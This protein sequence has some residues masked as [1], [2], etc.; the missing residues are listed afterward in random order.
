[1]PHHAPVCL[2]TL[3]MWVGHAE[4][5]SEIVHCRF[6][7]SQKHDHKLTFLSVTTTFIGMYVHTHIPR[8]DPSLRVLHWCTWQ[9]PL[10][11]WWCVYHFAHCWYQE[12]LVTLIWFSPGVWSLCSSLCVC[13][14]V[15]RRR[16]MIEWWR[17]THS[18]SEGSNICLQYAALQG[19][20]TG[21]SYSVA[22]TKYL[23]EW[24]F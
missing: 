10:I 19:F 7:E 11:I 13:A 21:V 15:F 1:M 23:L 2:C 14:G 6:S 12:F 9:W 16:R 5:V 3:R 17:R 4:Q 8:I 22:I 18:C 24:H 20:H